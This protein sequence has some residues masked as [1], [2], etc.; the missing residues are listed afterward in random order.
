MNNGKRLS[1]KVA[2]NQRV[3]ETALNRWGG[4]DILDDGF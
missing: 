4:V 3:V 1:G 2:D